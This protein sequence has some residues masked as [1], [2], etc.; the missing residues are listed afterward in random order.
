MKKY[1]TLNNLSWLLTLI[2]VFMLV[3]ASVTKLVGTSEAVG[4]FQFMNLSRYMFTVGL[5]EFVL[6]IGLVFPK[7]SDYAIVGVTAIMGGAIALH[8]SMMGGAGVMNPILVGLLAWS[9]HC[10]RKYKV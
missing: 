10:I 2:S 4:N 3:S 9:G 8:L 7:L 1:L 5:F 6:A